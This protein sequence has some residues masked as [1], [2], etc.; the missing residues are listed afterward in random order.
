M[1]NFS[2]AIDLRDPQDLFLY[3]A[4]R[5]GQDILE[6][7][8]RRKGLARLLGD[9]DTMPDDDLPGQAGFFGESGEPE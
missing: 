2:P 7:E 5:N 6:A 8:N 1:N 9:L 4:E 3:L